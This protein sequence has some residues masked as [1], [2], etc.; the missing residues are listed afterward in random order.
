MDRVAKR[1][2]TILKH[3]VHEV[4]SRDLVV[5][6]DQEFE[7]EEETTHRATK[8]VMHV[9]ECSERLP[10]GRFCFRG[11]LVSERDVTVVG[12]YP[13]QHGQGRL[14]EE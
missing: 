11:P 4:F 9:Q 14:F 5:G 13:D 8:L 10:S 12:V 2:W 7:V 6:T 3:S 1:Q